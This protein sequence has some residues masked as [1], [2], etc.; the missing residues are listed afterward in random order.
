[1]NFAG[2]RTLII[3]WLFDLLQNMKSIFGFN[4]WSIISVYQS[5]WNLCASFS[6]YQWIG[7]SFWTSEALMQLR[8]DILKLYSWK[9]IIPKFIIN[10]YYFFNLLGF[11]NIL[12]LD[13][14][15]WKICSSKIINKIII[16]I[17]FL[18]K[19]ILWETSI[20]NLSF[21]EFY[22]LKAST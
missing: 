15:Y 22:D 11:S 12:F 2:Y 16:H 10:N 19:K 9:I 6:K 7:C 20:S 3:H 5:D 13:N 1:M 14:Y 4:I 21:L 8:N 18:K 17:H